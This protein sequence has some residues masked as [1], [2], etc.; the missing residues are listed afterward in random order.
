MNKDWAKSLPSSF[1]LVL[2]NRHHQTTLSQGF[3]PSTTD[4][5]RV[6]CTSR[7]SARRYTWTQ[8]KASFSKD[9]TEKT[10]DFCD[11]FHVAR[12]PMFCLIETSSLQQP[13]EEKMEIF[14]T[15]PGVDC[16]NFKHIFAASYHS[17][18]LWQWQISLDNYVTG[19]LKGDLISQVS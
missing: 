19:F 6:V 3:F 4:W 9:A 11:N 8:P 1:F 2:V 17:P 13:S 14:K 18:G 12:R 7:C 10:K 15:I 5:K 16:N